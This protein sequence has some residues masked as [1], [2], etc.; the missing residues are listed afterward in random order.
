VI[1]PVA[2]RFGGSSFALYDLDTI[3]GYEKPD[4]FGYP[5][6]RRPYENGTALSSG[7]WPPATVAPP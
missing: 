6:S 3:A 1:G 5:D 4:C 7:T 2:A